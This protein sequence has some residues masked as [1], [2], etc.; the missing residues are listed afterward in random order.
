MTMT[1]STARLG[2]RLPRPNPGCHRLLRFELD[3]ERSSHAWASIDPLGTKA[4]KRPAAAT[5]CA[6][7]AP[8]GRP[9]DVRTEPVGGFAGP[10]PP[11]APVGTFANARLVRRQC[12]GS[13]AGDPDR[14]R[15]GSFADAD[16]RAAD[17]IALSTRRA[18]AR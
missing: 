2:D 1:G 10:V 3:I 15:Q 11:D 13:F 17:R 9:H 12:A 16:G 5:P 7:V 18:I 8:D 14:H 4:R 6:V